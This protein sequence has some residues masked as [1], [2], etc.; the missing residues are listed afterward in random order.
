MQSQLWAVRGA[1][2]VAT[3]HPA[4]RP[5]ECHRQSIHHA[6]LLRISGRAGLTSAGRCAVLFTCGSGRDDET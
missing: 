4:Q 6:W 3:H 1:V 2:P 5:A